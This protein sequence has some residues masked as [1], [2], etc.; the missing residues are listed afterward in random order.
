MLS[1]VL[2]PRRERGGEGEREREVRRTYL[3]RYRSL[4][5]VWLSRALI[6]I[7]RIG[8]QFSRKRFRAFV[9]REKS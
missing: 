3:P 5:L 8:W 2:F 9:Q 4:T 1:F 6:E 7:S